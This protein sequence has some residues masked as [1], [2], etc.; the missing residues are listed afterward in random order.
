[1]TNEHAEFNKTKNEILV[2]DDNQMNLQ[3]L[4]SMLAK[5]GY[6]VSTAQDGEQ[7]LKVVAE[8]LPSLILL[9]INIPGVDGYEVCRRLKS[10]ES[11]RNIPVVFLS[12]LEA[13]SDKVKALDA[14]GVDYI[15]K[16]F[17]M[18]EVLARIKLHLDLRRLQV[19]MEKRTAALQHINEM[20]EQEISDREQAEKE[21]KSMAL[22]AELN[23]DPVLR[24]DRDG[25]VIMA[26]PA[27]VNILGRRSLNGMPLTSII[28]GLE[29][30][31]FSACISGSLTRVHSIQIGDNFFHFIFKGISELEIGNIY[32]SDITDQKKA[33]AETLR[34]SQ[35]ASLGE[36]AAGVAH[37]INNPIN[38]IINYAQIIVNSSMQDTQEH[39]IAKRIIHEGDRI[40]GIVKNLLTFARDRGGEKHPVYIS[41]IIS[42]A[43]SL[44]ETQLR[45]D[46]IK[47]NVSIP[48]Q[49]PAIMAQHQQ[50]EQVFLNIISNSRYALNRKYSEANANKMIAISAEQINDN[51]SSCMQISFYDQGT[52]IQKELLDKI[53]NPFYSTKPIGEGTGLGLSISNEII[54]DHGGEINVESVEGEYTKV[55]I[56]LPSGM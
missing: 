29:E 19:N 35:L 24:F 31:D 52:G 49:L 50:L 55:M 25:K 16:P 12:G 17:Q 39:D 27:A 4:K 22:F 56:N 8:N 45:K 2:V 20:L 11:S 48:P 41:E 37:E 5:A 53:M 38:G 7:A 1:M 26:N 6:I 13:A 18:E 43:L 42:E 10:D 32:G 14:G 23:P 33:E 15:T 30:T 36:L 3:M 34:T 28:P 47:I 46:S 9:D 40:A 21:V 44:T 54:T 51:T